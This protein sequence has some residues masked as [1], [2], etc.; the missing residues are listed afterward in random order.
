M[1]HSRVAVTFVSKVL[2]LVFIVAWGLQ[3]MYST[4]RWLC[5]KAAYSLLHC[6]HWKSTLSSKVYPPVSNA[7]CTWPS[8]LYAIVPSLFT[9]FGE[10][11]S[12]HW[13]NCSTGWILT[14][15]NS[16]K[17]KQPACTS[18]RSIVPLQKFSHYV[19]AVSV[20]SAPSICEVWRAEKRFEVGC[21]VVLV[22]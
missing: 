12:K 2:Q 20:A 21:N 6:L 9:L 10:I 5:L 18:A 4:R 15:L 1:Q 14:V 13:I 22:I 17:P 3:A 8:S 7:L 11:F 16:Q 19:M